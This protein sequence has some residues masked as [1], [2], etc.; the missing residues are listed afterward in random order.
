VVSKDRDAS[1]TVTAFS[2]AP[3]PATVTS[4]GINAGVI[5]F[6]FA[7]HPAAITGGAVVQPP[8]PNLANGRPRDFRPFRVNL[9][10]EASVERF[11]FATHRCEISRI[12]EWSEEDDEDMMLILAMVEAA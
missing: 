7:T 6:A 11:D 3:H 1:A 5:A 12:I 9:A 4:G 2:F 10:V 8:T